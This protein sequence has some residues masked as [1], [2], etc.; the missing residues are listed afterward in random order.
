MG[1]IHNHMGNIHNET[2]LWNDQGL[3][4]DLCGA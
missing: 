3:H 2:N 1:N 4:V